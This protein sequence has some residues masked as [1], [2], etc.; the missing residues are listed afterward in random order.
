MTDLPSGTVTFLF[1]DIEGSTRLLEE[2]GADA[3]A[4]ALA[5]HR[6]V[7]RDA[8]GR[9]GGVEVDTQ[10]DAFFYVF[11]D[12]GAALLAARDGQAALAEGSIAVRMGVHTGEALRGEAG[13]VGREVH[14][15]ARIG[16]AGHG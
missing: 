7:L 9:H 6:R 1:T 3:Y 10:G 14:R 11:A 2:L 8:F 15:A 12:P 16:A 13:Y 5:E 4:K